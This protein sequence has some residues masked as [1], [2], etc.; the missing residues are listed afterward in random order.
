MSGNL[1]RRLDRVVQQTRLEPRQIV[2]TLYCIDVR[3]RPEQPGECIAP[4]WDA[5]LR[6]K[7]DHEGLAEAWLIS[8][9]DE[10][11][12]DRAI[13]ELTARGEVPRGEWSRYEVEPCDG[14]ETCAHR[15]KIIE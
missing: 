3:E 8:A 5:Y 4:G 9:S 10:Q 14:G 1:A 12:L 15:P 11:A 2:T 6:C 7:P 13:D